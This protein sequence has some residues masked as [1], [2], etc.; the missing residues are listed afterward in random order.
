MARVLVEVDLGKPLPQQICFK[1]R[2]G[3]EIKVAVHY[4]W[5]PPCCSLCSKWGHTFK[6]CQEQ[7]SVA[8]LKRSEVEIPSQHT[9]KSNEVRQRPG[10]DIVSDLMDELA[11]FPVAPIS[12]CGE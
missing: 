4:P 5:L 7:G 2:E 10:K 8:I 12:T 11:Q 1:G 9:P 6:D 3:Q